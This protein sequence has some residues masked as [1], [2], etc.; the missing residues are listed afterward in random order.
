MSEV[1]LTSFHFIL[2]KWES[3]LKLVAGSVWLP[4]YASIMGTPQ[5]TILAESNRGERGALNTILDPS[6]K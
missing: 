4:A 3:A 2:Y 6:E 1:C 5:P